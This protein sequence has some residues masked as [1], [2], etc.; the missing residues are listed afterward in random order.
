MRPI[1]AL[2]LM[3]GMFFFVSCGA[4][5]VSP[6]AQ[7]PCGDLLEQYAKKPENLEFIECKKGTGQTKFEANYKVVGKHA[8]NVEAFFSKNYGMGKLKFLCCGWEPNGKNG[9]VKSKALKNDDM[10]ISMW[11]NAEKENPDGSVRLERDRNK[12]DFS[13]RVRILDI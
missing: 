9:W 7:S 5:K 2:S 1:S 10:E 11:G 12:I 13:V 6:S 8:R 4:Q 3:L